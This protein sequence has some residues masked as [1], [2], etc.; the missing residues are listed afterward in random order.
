M[1][2]PTALG[3]MRNTKF[4]A[5]RLP[6]GSFRRTSFRM[7]ANRLG[8]EKG[9]LLTLNPLFLE[10]L[11]DAPVLEFRNRHHDAI[12]DLLARLFRVVD[13]ILVV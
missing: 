2:S 12:D 10:I 8:F 6:H 5:S 7:E 9:G 3:Q 1:P 4:L 13:G 11:G